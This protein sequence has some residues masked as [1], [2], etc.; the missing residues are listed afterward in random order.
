[1]LYGSETWVVSKTQQKLAEDTEMKFFRQIGGCTLAVRTCND[2]IRQ[3][4]D[5]EDITVV[6]RSYKNEHGRVEF[7][8]K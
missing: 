5:G 3:R 1:M 7:Q 4:M 6:T 2:I 8:D